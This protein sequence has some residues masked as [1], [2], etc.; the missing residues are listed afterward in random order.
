MTFLPRSLVLVQ[1]D[2]CGIPPASLGSAPCHC[3]LHSIL[4][5]DRTHSSEIVLGLGSQISP[6]NCNPDSLGTTF[7]KS[8]GGPEAGSQACPETWKNGWRPRLQD[9]PSPQV[10]IPPSCQRR[11]C[12]VGHS[13]EKEQEDQPGERHFD[14]FAAKTEE[15]GKRI[16]VHAA[17]DR[18]PAATPGDGPKWPGRG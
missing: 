1:P 7:D 13:E 10:P 11:T 15:G 17:A 16:S 3:S 14:A 2:T 6:S 4:I 8:W 5:A 12:R 18:A 9:R